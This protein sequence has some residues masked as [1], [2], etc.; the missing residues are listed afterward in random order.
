MSGGYPLHIDA[1]SEHGKGGVFVCLDGWRGWVLQA[2]KISSENADELRP[3]IEETIQR[4]G[5]PIAVV[6]DLSAA[7]AGA[8]DELR[9]KGIPDLVC[10]YHFLGAIGKKLFDDL[11]TVLRNLLR[12]S[13]VRTLHYMRTW[14]SR[15]DM[16]SFVSR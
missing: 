3:C 13:K 5:D 1:T 14:R 15:L 4:F 11:H 6:R 2:V 7:E 8:V 16:P 9:E 10:H 12:L